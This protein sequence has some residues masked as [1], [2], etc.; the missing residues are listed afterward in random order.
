MLRRARRPIRLGRL[1]PIRRH[2]FFGSLGVVVVGLRVASGFFR[3]EV[4]RRILE[5]IRGR[6]LVVLLGPKGDDAAAVV[7]LAEHLEGRLDVPEFLRVAALVGVRG[8]YFAMI[9]PP[10][11]LELL[12]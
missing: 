1:D 11:D 3:G 8:E 5:Y 10:N 9:R 4:V 6:R 7:K 12:R 2:V